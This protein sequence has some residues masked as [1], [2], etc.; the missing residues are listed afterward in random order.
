MRYRAGTK[1]GVFNRMKKGWKRSEESKPGHRFQDRYLRRQ[2][3]SSGRV[4][5]GMIVTS[6]RAIF[7]VLGGIVAVPGP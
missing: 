2:R 6:A 7:N 1:V 4:R 5:A 3:S